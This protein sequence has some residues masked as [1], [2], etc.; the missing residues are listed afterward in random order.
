MIRTT[1]DTIRFP[2]AA[3][4]RAVCYKIDQVTTDL[5]CFDLHVDEDDRARHYTVHEEMP[6][7]PE[8]IAALEQLAG[9]NR[10]WR[11][12]VVEPPFARNE[13]VAF[14]LSVVG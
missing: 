13:T 12:I 9:F 7:F 2:L 1:R 14:D 10:D 4:R 8:L 3:I 11:Q 5:I 6:G